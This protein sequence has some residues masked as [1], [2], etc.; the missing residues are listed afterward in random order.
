[1]DDNRR[2]PNPLRVRDALSL[3]TQ[4]L[5]EAGIDSAG[6]N[7]R[8]LLCSV[9]DCEKSDLPFLNDRVLTESEK[10][11]FSLFIA[12]R[13]AGEPLQ[14]ITGKAPFRFI[15]LAVCPGVLIP[16]PETEV[17]VGEVLSW[18][19]A[20]DESAIHV[21]DIGCGSGAIAC[22]LAFEDARIVV[23][24]TDLSPTAVLVTQ[25]NA[26]RLGL[27]ER[28]HVHEGNLGEPLGDNV[29]ASFH[30]IVS[31]PPYVPTEVV[32]QL[33]REIADYEPLLALDGGADG[34]DVFRELLP[35]AY[36]A[37]VPGGLFA[38][39]LFE[40]SFEEAVRLANETGFIKTKTVQDLAG[41]ERVL[42]S[43]K[44]DA[45]EESAAEANAKNHA[46]EESNRR[47]VLS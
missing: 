10:A 45:T 1:M 46:T 13:A 47:G 32:F 27:S 28:A 42:L 20:R 4:K 11:I 34:L 33:G 30:A 18:I 25:E 9:L 6:V 21:A 37:L 44:A 24:A 16:R 26:G 31:N 43:W 29:D 7:A 15:E 19:S 22:S 23:E 40:G 35:W 12:R 39:E 36:R 38:V 8:E 2:F 17:L 5:D 3:E 14:L 41:R